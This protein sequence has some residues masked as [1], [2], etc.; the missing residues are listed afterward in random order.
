[1]SPTPSAS[2]P[3]GDVA[4]RPS[5]GLC[6]RV[7]AVLVP[8]GDPLLGRVREERAAVAELRFD[9]PA[10]APPDRDEERRARYLLESLGA[11][12][13]ACLEE[14]TVYPGS[15]AD[16]IIRADGNVHG[17]CSFTAYAVPQLRAL[18][19]R[20]DL[21]E[22]YPVP[23]RRRGRARGTRTSPTTSS[24]GGSTSSSASRSTA[25]A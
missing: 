4:S 21:P 10:G 13:L 9:Y 16:Y 7:E 2:A 17:L 6:L 18:G 1:M 12:E 23:G 25:A 3:Q 8:D 20:V 14:V 5:V 22:D 11:L 24:P 19:W 15:K